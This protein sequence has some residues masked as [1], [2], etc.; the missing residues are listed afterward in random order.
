MI[1]KKTPLDGLLVIEP[2]RFLDERGAFRETFVSWRYRDIGVQDDFVQDNHSYSKKNVL[3]GLHYQINKPQAQLLSV[4]SGVIFD[5]CVDLRP[6]SNSFGEWYG[7]CLSSADQSQIYMPPGFA[8]GFLV[9]SETADLHY[10]VSRTYD[11]RDEGGLLWKDPGIGIKWPRYDGVIISPR[12]MSY[13][14]LRDIPQ[15][16]LPQL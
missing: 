5:V 4:L 8:H 9:L 11:E 2:G 15:E 3:R 14:L 10:K 1:T 7:V 6:K 16:R 12:D 13:P